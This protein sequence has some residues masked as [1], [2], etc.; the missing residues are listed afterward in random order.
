MLSCQLVVSYLQCLTD[1]YL[2][3]SGQ[4]RIESEWDL[5]TDRND[6]NIDY[7]GDDVTWIIE[8]VA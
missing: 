2:V 1:R 7:C 5:L 6:F 8:P 4:G 3:E